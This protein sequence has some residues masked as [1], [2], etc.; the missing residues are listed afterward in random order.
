MR[1]PRWTTRLELALADPAALRI[2]DKISIVR[3]ARDARPDVSEATVERWIQEA[4]SATRLQRVV[5]G[6]YLNRLISPPAQLSE[7]AV[8]LRPG[9]VISLQT[10][11][12]DAGVWDNFTDWVTAVVPF[13][14]RYTTPSLGRLETAAGIFVFRGLPETVLE[15][16]REEDRLASGPTYRRATP[17]AA[18]LH[19]LYLSNPPRSRMS[20]PPLD[21]DLTIL[22]AQ[23]L[24]RL[25]RAMKLS[26]VLEGWL[27]RTDGTSILRRM[28]RPSSRHVD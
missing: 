18:L 1:L 8:W 23:R 11:L 15:A 10:V 14:P 26:G 12:G 13:S 21:M 7:A 3:L 5:R 6:L 16:G 4:V 17:E 19:W 24:K 25:S 2:L 9:A 28:G 20:E 22:N 27:L